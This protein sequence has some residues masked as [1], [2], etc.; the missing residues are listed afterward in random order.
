MAKKKFTVT[1]ARMVREQVDVIV[2][3]ESEDDIDLKKVYYDYIG[4]DWEP[5]VEWGCDP[6]THTIVAADDA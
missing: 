3:A 5:D 4:N 6:G 1:L 2:E